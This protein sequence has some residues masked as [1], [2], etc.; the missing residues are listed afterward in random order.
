MYFH[1]DPY[2]TELFAACTRIHTSSQTMCSATDMYE[3]SAACLACRCSVPTHATCFARL[4][5]R[6]CQSCDAGRKERSI[7][8]ITVRVRG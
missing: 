3:S 1:H 2:L 8:R 7:T 6:N 4:S 5:A